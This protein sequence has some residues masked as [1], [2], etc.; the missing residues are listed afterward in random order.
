MSSDTPKRSLIWDFPIRAFHWML[1]IAIVV[2]FISVNRDEMEIHFAS[3]S[4]VLALVIF[5][6]LWGLIGP[7][8]AQ[9]HVFAPLPARIRAWREGRAVGHSPHGA[10]ATFAL[11]GLVGAQAVTGLFTDDEMF[12]RGPLRSE[13]TRSTAYWLTDLHAAISNVLLAMIA[14]HLAAIAFYTII[15]R[16]DILKVFVTGHRQGGYGVTAR[17]WPLILVCAGIAAG[18][19]WYV[20]S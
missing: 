19:S 13:V 12:L 17:P 2:S 9:F 3:G 8:T 16:S 1:V 11:L 5:R 15:K 10:L 4:V 18:A 7:R 14:L 6:L 20:F